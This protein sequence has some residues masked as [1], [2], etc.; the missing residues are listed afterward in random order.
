MNLILLWIISCL[1]C[2]C[3]GAMAGATDEDNAKASALLSLVLMLILATILIT[4]WIV[5]P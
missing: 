1:F 3:V 5:L 4:R 2:F